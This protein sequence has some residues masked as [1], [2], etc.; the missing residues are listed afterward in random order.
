VTDLGEL[1]VVFVAGFGPIVKD[2]PASQAL[3]VRAL[4]LPLQARPDDPD[5]FHGETLDGVRHF[6]LWPI[7]SAAQSC[8]GTD[9]WPQDVPVPQGWIEFDVEDVRTASAVLKQRGYTL[10]VDAR[11]EPWG[12]TVTRLLSPEG[13]LVGLTYT[14]WLR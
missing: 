1:K 11:E 6:A 13:L 4:G 14:P 3:Y 7:A 5:Y 9:R 8:F 2:P 10:L 12:Q